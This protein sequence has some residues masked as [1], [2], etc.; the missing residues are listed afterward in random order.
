MERFESRHVSS[1]SVTLKNRTHVRVI[2]EFILSKTKYTF[3]PFYIYSQALHW[4]NKIDILSMA[5]G[6]HAPS[7]TCIGSMISLK[8][9]ETFYVTPNFEWQHTYLDVYIYVQTCIECALG[10]IR[11]VT[12]RVCFCH[13]TVNQLAVKAPVWN[14][15][16]SV[17][18]HQTC[19]SVRNT[20]CWPTHERHSQL[21]LGEV[22]MP[23]ADLDTV[24]REYGAFGHFPR[25][26]CN[27]IWIHCERDPC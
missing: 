14:Q 27:L 1:K 25:F 9:H 7:S 19:E 24:A 6:V 26:R 11:H 22:W 18:W 16:S 4:H 23:A 20:N 12:L 3:D 21:L 5:Q 17:M 10:Y 15:M 2:T 13:T 8:K